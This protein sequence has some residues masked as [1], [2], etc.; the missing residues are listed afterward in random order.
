M[1]Q[2]QTFAIFLFLFHLVPAQQKEYKIPDSLKNKSYDYLDDM[3][4]GL[5]DSSKA[6]I[7][8]YSFLQKA[9]NEKNWKEIANGYSNLSNQSSDKL[10]IIYADSTIYAAKKTNDNIL[11]GSAYLSKGIAY[12]SLKQHNYALDNYIIAH[13]YLATTTDKYLIYK[14]MYN[15]AL[16]KYYLGYYDEAISLLKQCV[17][18][19]KNENPRAYLNSLHFLGVCYNK[20]G[21]Y[22]LSSETNILGIKECKK[23]NI[24]EMEV[25]YIHSQGIND[26]FKQNYASAIKN[27]E[28]SIKELK[29]KKDFGNESVGYFYIGKSYWKTEK[30]ET[31]LPYL[32]K[33]DQLFN[34]KGYLRPDLRE[35]YEILINYY[36]AKDN[37]EIHLYYVDQLLKA[38][39]MLNET[40]KYLV[41]KINKEYYTQE[42]LIDKENL[43]R[44]LFIKNY[45]YSVLIGFTSIIFSG[46]IIVT[47]RNLRNK[48]I[49]KKRF[50]ELMLEINDSKDKSKTK[51]KKEKPIMLDINSETV[52]IILKLLDKFENE[53]KYLDRDWK[54]STLSAFFNHNPT[55]LS[56]IIHHYKDK[57]F[58]QYIND[59]KTEYIISLLY[60]NKLVRKYNNKALAEEV[61]F[62]TTERFAKAF[63]KKTGISAAY[64]IEQIKKEDTTLN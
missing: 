15:I 29:E 8:L 62:S 18:Y 38:D 28:Y 12:Y 46:F 63:K 4:Y 49:Y 45:K 20:I 54:L 48:K 52:A 27:I 33:V 23:L 55:Y 24:P 9:K 3:A 56:A 21:N 19:F 11:I 22:G 53:K 35:V 60:S 13:S 44:E 50:E 7:Y 40:F 17:S 39:R 30:Y 37:P 34:T 32:K 25:Y 2:N 58:N 59:L 61:G 10:T 42:L 1:N 26:Y 6:T 57:R 5:K 47:H 36:K 16:V 64:F 41:G 31:A 14:L 43:K 51:E